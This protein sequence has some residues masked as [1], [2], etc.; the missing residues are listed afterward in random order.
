MNR[1]TDLFAKCRTFKDAKRVQ[2]A[3]V[4]PFFRPI[5][6][7]C[8]S[9][10]I[11]HGRRRVMIGSNNYLGL[12]HHPRVLAAAKSAIDH[13]GT[14]CTGSRFLN[15]NLVLH[16]QL[17]QELA[18]FL[19]REA[20][21]VFSTGVAANMGS[22][23]CLVGR[24]DVIY[25]DRENH[26][27]IMD[28]TQLAI[29]DTIKFRH[30][31]MVDLERLLFSTREK[32]QGALIVAD[33]VFSMS[34][35][36]FKLPEAVALAKKYQCRLYIDDAHALG[37]LGPKGQGTESHFNMPGAADLVIGTFSKSFASIGGYAAGSAEVI[38]YIKHKARSFIFSAAMPPAAAA[39]ALE[40]LRIVQEDTSR[41]ARLWNNTHRMNQELCQM[42]YDTLNSRTPIIPLV[43]GNDARAFQFA[44]NLYD[45]GVFATPVVRPAV[46]EGG[47][48]IRTSYMATHTDEDLEYVL[49]TLHLLGK[50][51]RIIGKR[52]GV[53]ADSSKTLCQGHN[54]V[55]PRLKCG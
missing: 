39:T 27:S 15:G 35:D 16:E 24:K 21:V 20:C 30:N 36:I 28:S 40:C 45:R 38:H 12:T 9:G 50:N 37:V 3:G 26:A 53:F 10:V 17:E 43:I 34:G 4:Y 32:Y 47:A 22:I 7:T 1:E 49:K 52:S 18:S 6:A 46:Q 51:L 42:G 31:D 5:E 13:Y 23:S 48:L 54:T 44:Q 8:G 11:S 33:G 14:G 25:C 2:A 19:G 41:H 29:S 55:L